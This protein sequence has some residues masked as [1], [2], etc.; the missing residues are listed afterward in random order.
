MKTDAN[1][2]KIDEMQALVNSTNEDELKSL[3]SMVKTHRE[4]LTKRKIKKLR[5]ND[6]VEFISKSRV[7]KGNI[8][9]VNIKRVIVKTD[10]GATWDIPPLMLTVIA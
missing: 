9:K 1:W 2:K 5:I 3:T 8:T 6:R 7:I 4:I 10:G